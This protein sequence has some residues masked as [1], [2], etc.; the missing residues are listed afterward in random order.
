M[1]G[2]FSVDGGA[3]VPGVVDDVLQLVLSHGCFL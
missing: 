1:G 2:V 3:V